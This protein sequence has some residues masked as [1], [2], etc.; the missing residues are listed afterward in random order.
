VLPTHVQYFTRQSLGTLLARHDFT[1]VHTGTAPKAFTVGYYAGRL[2][3][4]SRGLARGVTRTV[5]LTGVADRL[6]APD[7]R[8]RMLVIARR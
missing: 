5:E 8:D 2:G 7:F 6:W 4:Y 1:V 3:G